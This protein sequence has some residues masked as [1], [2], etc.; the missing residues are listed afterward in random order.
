MTWV[1]SPTPPFDHLAAR[2]AAC[3]SWRDYPDSRKVASS[4]IDPGEWRAVARA[5]PHSDR[6]ENQVRRMHAVDTPRQAWWQD[7]CPEPRPT[8]R[9]RRDG[10]ARAGRAAH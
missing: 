4:K 8:G 9:G 7:D 5:A 1:P 2:E 3:R 10:G 6:G